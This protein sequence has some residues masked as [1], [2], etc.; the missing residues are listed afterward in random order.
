[1]ILTAVAALVVA[2]LP[3]AVLFRLPVADR[4]RRAALPAEERLFWHVV[5]SLAVSLTVALVL[6]A[7]SA[8]RLDRLVAITG[9]LTL[10]LVLGGRGALFYRGTA[11]RP[12]ISLTPPLLLVVLAAIQFFPASEYIIGG[13]DPGGYINQGVLIAE[14]GALVVHEPEIVDLPEPVRSLFFT[15]NMR[16]EYYDNR[17]MGFFLRNPESG[18]VVGQFP[19][20]YPASIAVAYGLGG[21]RGALGAVGFWAVLGVVAVYLLGA[22]LAGR[23]AAFAA[24]VLLTLNLAEVFFGGYPNTEVVM[25]AVLFAALLAFARAHQDHD[26]FFA[27]VAGLLAALLIFLRQDA[28]LAI[29]ALGAAAVLAWVVD[30]RRPRL[31][32]VVPLAAGLL[33]GWFYWTGPMRATFFRTQMYLQRLPAW[34]VLGGLVV[35]AAGIAIAL[36]LKRAHGQWAR[37]AVPVAVMVVLVTLALYAWFL[38]VPGGRLAAHDAATFRTFVSLYFLPLGMVLALAGL[39]VLL[40]R[41]FWQDPAFVIVTAV[42]AGFFFFKLQIV[43]E[44]LWMAR[45]FLP[46]ILPA[47]LLFA[48]AAALGTWERWPKGPQVIRV[49]VGVIVLIILGRQYQIA[50]APA[51]GHVEFQGLVD[52]LD[53]LAKR[54][55]D[56]DLVIVE[57]RGSS[58]VHVMGIP[59]AY[60]HGRRVLVLESEVP[61]KP[62]FEMFL[63]DAVKRYDRV[64][65]LGGGGTDLLSPGIRATPVT[66]VQREAPSFVVS[67]WNA[68]RAGVRPYKFHYSLYRL[69]SAPTTETGFSLDVGFE[70]DLQV[71]RFS[72]KEVTEGRSFR[73]TGDQSFVAVR[74]LTGREREIALVMHD[75]GRPAAAPPAT[76]EV[77][78]ADVSLGRLTVTSGFREYR[79]AIPAE[80]LQGAMAAAGRQLRLLATVWRPS[81]FSSSTDTRE[82]GVMV[83]R[84]EIR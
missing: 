76:L 51:A 14:R 7:M 64:F 10:T 13:K 17:F 16:R 72:D 84:V 80:A 57:S 45:R 22:R 39:A 32:F 27:P 53:D 41:R 44:H 40:P 33:I 73:W 50:A 56:R 60:V 49:I 43:P 47:A 30:D 83:D 6:A 3:G 82:L 36:R 26:A 4:D 67:P 23:P 46:V 8:Y 5:I 54:F 62:T 29:A 55:S 77:L 63:A 35:A 75:G 81:E 28:P 70:D 61:D 20:V 48:A 12:T 58:D 31:G 78:L 34:A 74:G 18:A 25:Q 15:D 69:E 52:H 71:V 9:G 19:H 65:F 59:L 38:R 79:L 2:Y 37:R 1:M 21:I 24:A 42:F 68:F 66:Y 11:A